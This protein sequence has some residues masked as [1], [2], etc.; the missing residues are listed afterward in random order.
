MISRIKNATSA[1]A[2]KSGDSCYISRW[3]EY[4]SHKYQQ[5][6]RK[7][8]EESAEKKN[9]ENPKIRISASAWRKELLNT[10][11]IVT[12]KNVAECNQKKSDPYEPQRGTERIPH[13]E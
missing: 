5:N 12:N 11:I 7:D 4:H 8:R 6:E 1:V 9:S 3:K 13:I 10:E 2:A